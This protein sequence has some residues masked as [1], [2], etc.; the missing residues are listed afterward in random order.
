MRRSGV[1]EA[2]LAERWGALTP[3]NPNPRDLQRSRVVSYFGKHQATAFDMMRTKMVQQCKANDWKRIAITSPTPK[4]GKT[5]TTANLG[6]SL[7]RHA[8]MRIIIVELD[9][10][11]PALAATLGIKDPH[12]FAKSLAGREAPEDHLLCFAGNLAFG[13]N[14]AA[15]ANPS[16]LLQSAQT[17]ES[18]ARL[19]EYFQPDLMIFDTAPLL[20]SDDTI[21]F[22]QNVDA[23]LLIAAAEMTTIEEIDVAE[24]EISEVCEVMGVVLNKCR[25]G[26]AGYG[27]EYG[28]GYGY[29]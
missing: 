27:Y 19:E 3:F 12:Y 9:L 21:G 10:R 7:A 1:S 15:A 22:L 28:Y 6:F 24:S 16:E 17:Q 14:Q 2:E 25:Y 13:T 26:G 4:C 23:T 18:L 20:A 11:R 5:T 29:Y 8:D